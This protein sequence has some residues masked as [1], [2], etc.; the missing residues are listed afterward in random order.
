MAPCLLRRTRNQQ[1]AAHSFTVLF[2]ALD[3]KIPCFSVFDIPVA[4]LI[5][6]ACLVA[7]LRIFFSLCILFVASVKQRLRLKALRNELLG[8]NKASDFNIVEC[9]FT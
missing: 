2:M 9:T 1:F 4:I 6:Y 7:F 8:P 5:N 3:M